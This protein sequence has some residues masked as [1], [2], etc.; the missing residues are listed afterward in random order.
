[1]ISEYKEK[2]LLFPLF[3]GIKDVDLGGML[4]CLN[5]NIREFEKDEYVY[6][7]QEEIKSIG[8]I[9]KG[10]V[11]MIREDMW[12]NKAILVNMA[13]SELFGETFACG[14]NM[15]AS[16]SFVSM[17]DSIILFLPFE[18]VMHSCSMTCVFHHRMIEN[19]VRLIADK[20]ALLMEKIDIISKK[21]L[22]EKIATFLACQ[23][24]KNESRTFDIHMGR[25]ELA[26]YLHA[27]RSALTREL[28]AM[29]T[30]GLISFEKKRFQIL[31]RL[32]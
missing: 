3:Y 22:R 9:I 32:V 27:D 29:Q 20:N 8:I 10:R 6:R 12:G 31:K 11:Q 19:M 17:E 25:I 28:N 4:T 1:M 5:A 13:E 23:A 7:D 21:T 30:E 24:E 26:E 16:V 15:N 14:S 2:L 18:R